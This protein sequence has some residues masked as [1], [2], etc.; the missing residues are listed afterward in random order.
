MMTFSKRNLERRNVKVKRHMTS[1]F[2]RRYVWHI[3]LDVMSKESVTSNTIVLSLNCIDFCPALFC[4]VDH[5]LWTRH[6]KLTVYQ[7]PLKLPHEYVE[8]SLS[9]QQ[10]P[11]QFEANGDRSSIRNYGYLTAI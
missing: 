2:M 3:I 4:S 7:L 6:I 8:L 1:F 9:S 10:Q 5:Y 11:N